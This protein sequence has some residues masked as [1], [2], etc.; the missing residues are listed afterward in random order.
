MGRTQ[1]MGGSAPVTDEHAHRVPEAVVLS[2]AA[3]FS[4]PASA[5]FT[6][7]M[8]NCPRARNVHPPGERHYPMQTP[9]QLT[10][11]SVPRSDALAI[12]I[13]QRAGKL[14]HLFD[15]I[16]SCHVVVEFAGHHHRH[17]DQYRYTIH[18]GPSGARGAHHAPSAGGAR[19][20]GRLRDGRPSLRRGRA[21]AR[22]LGEGSARA[23]SRCGASWTPPAQL[24]VIPANLRRPRCTART[25]SSN[26]KLARYDERKMV[27]N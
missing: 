25:R 2:L 10:F 26:P 5:S 9:P 21:P 13:R 4:S 15:R 24:N 18:V 27:E 19:P 23:T 17:G 1:D 14:D 20:S 16:I 7:G 8:T 11:R 6:L 12:H 3:L 22:T